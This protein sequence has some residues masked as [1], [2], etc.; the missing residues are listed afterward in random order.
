MQIKPAVKYHLTP[1]GM[2]TFQKQTITTTKPRKLQMLMAI[3]RNLHTN[4]STVGGI[5]D[6]EAIVE[7]CTEVP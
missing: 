6:D 7:N 3:W 1:T 5:K 2:V 4:V